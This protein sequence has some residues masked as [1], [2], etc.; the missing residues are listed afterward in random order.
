MHVTP[1]TRSESLPK[2]LATRA[3]L[4]GLAVVGSRERH[5]RVS[6]MQRFAAHVPQLRNGK[7]LHAGHTEAYVASE[8]LNPA[9]PTKA[10][11]YTRGCGM[12]RNPHYRRR[13][14][15]YE[16]MHGFAPKGQ[17]N[18]PAILTVRVIDC[19]NVSFTNSEGQR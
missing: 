10:I 9:N 1:L 4:P 14:R 13:I 18:F 11:G 6:G 7:C 19:I 17:S 8:L 15:A 16:I 5:V 3:T 2:E 12:M